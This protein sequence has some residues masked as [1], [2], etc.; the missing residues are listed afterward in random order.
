MQTNILVR[1]VKL[2]YIKINNQVLIIGSESES[3]LLLIQY[4]VEELPWGQYWTQLCVHMYCAVTVHLSRG[5][6]GT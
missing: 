6:P 2:N 5:L 1:L 3:V 4:K